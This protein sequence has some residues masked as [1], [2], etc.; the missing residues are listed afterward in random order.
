MHFSN[1]FNGFELDSTSD[2]ERMLSLVDHEVGH[3]V[4]NLMDEYSVGVSEPTGRYL[5]NCQVGSGGAPTGSALQWKDWVTAKTAAGSTANFQAQY[6]SS[7]SGSPNFDV[8]STPDAVC[9]FTNYYKPNANCMMHRLNDFFMCPVCREQATLQLF[10]SAKFVYEFPRFPFK[11]QVLLVSTDESIVPADEMSINTSSTIVVHLNRLLTVANGFTVRAFDTD[12]SSLTVI[13]NYN[14]PACIVLGPDNFA[15]YTV[16]IEARIRVTITDDTKSFVLPANRDLHTSQLQQETFF[17]IVLTDDHPSN[18]TGADFY[19]YST[20]NEYTADLGDVGYNESDLIPRYVFCLNQEVTWQTR[21]LETGLQKNNSFCSFNLSREAAPYV[22]PAALQAIEAD[23]D[24]WVPI[25][26]AITAIVF[27]LLWLWASQQYTEMSNGKIRPIFKTELSGFLTLVRTIMTASAV[28]FLLASLGAIGAAAYAYY[29]TSLLGKI[30]VI[31][32]VVLAVILYLMAFFGFWAVS[33]RSKRM[34][35][36]NGVVLLIPLGIGIWLLI[37]LNAF[38]RELDGAA[39]WQPT[40][41]ATDATTGVSAQDQVNS[42]LK[43]LEELWIWMV[44]NEPNWAC[45]FQGVLECSG[46]YTN[47]AGTLG[48]TATCPSTCPDINERFISPCQTRLQDYIVEHYSV[49]VTA[50]AL[51]TALLGAG[52]LLNTLNFLLLWSEKS[53]IQNRNQNTIKKEAA[54]LGNPALASS[55]HDMYSMMLLKTLDKRD[56]HSLIREFK[57]IDRDGNGELTRGELAFFINGALKHKPSKA[58]VDKIFSVA[59]LDNNGTISLRE[60]LMIFGW[61]SGDIDNV[62]RPTPKAGPLQKMASF[63]RRSGKEAPPGYK[64][65]PPPVSSS[66]SSP[67]MFQKLRGAPPSQ[68]APRPPPR[69]YTPEQI[70]SMRTQMR[71]RAKDVYGNEFLDASP[72]A[73][74]G[75]SP[76]EMTAVSSTTNNTPTS[77]MVAQQQQQ[78]VQYQQRPAASSVTQQP[79]VPPQQQQQMARKHVNDDF[80]L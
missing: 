41:N 13:S 62:N 61:E 58:E 6:A 66:S 17:R 59:Y 42:W 7:L 1:F 40:L 68:Q 52:F 3:S 16:D 25:V 15:K 70:A 51:G 79:V 10:E 21:N 49:A 64:P 75:M 19:N 36:V 26:L 18:I 37:T 20:K 73:N 38:G 8:L 33:S 72:Q 32:G 22:Q 35:I 44:D 55:K 60:F 56:R 34:L 69:Q 9:G 76:R 27:I 29:N 57:R 67:S 48:S 11:D 14:C 46:Y 24:T 77:T 2:K 5:R 39:T 23:L 4:G 47:C 45:S 12:E 80:E 50:V 71:Q 78:Q 53:K 28:I 54:R 31:F 30:F 63:A 65:G 43:K 74:G